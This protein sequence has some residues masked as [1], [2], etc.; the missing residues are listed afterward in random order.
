MK[1]YLTTIFLFVFSVAFFAQTQEVYKD[2]LN[3]NLI[4]TG[5]LF[6]KIKTP[7]ANLLLFT[8]KNNKTVNKPIEWLSL[9]HNIYQ[10]EYQTKLKHFLS[11][12]N[13]AKPKLK[14]SI[15]EIGILNYQFNKISEDAYKD[16]RA[17]FIDS[18]IIITNPNVIEKYQVF[19]VSPIMVKKNT[20]KTISFRFNQNTYFSNYESPVNY[21]MV[22]FGNNSGK[23]K[24]FLNDLISVKYNTFGKKNL[25][26]E[27]FLQN[28]EHFNSNFQIEVTKMVMPTPNETWANYTA[29]ISY[30]GGFAS[31]DVGVFLGYGNT[32]FTRPV[33]ISDG[34]DPGDTRDLSQ[35]YDLINQQNMVENLR[36][37]G[38]DLIIVNFNGGDD[39]IQKNAML[40]VKV[41]QTINNRMLSAGTLKS[42][43]QIAVVGPSMSGLVSRYALRYMEQNGMN[44]NVRNWIA[45]DSPMKGANI[46]L[47]LQHWL[48]FYAQV[49]DVA[50]AQQALQAL[51]GPAAKQMLK[52]YYTATSGITAG[53]HSLFTSFYNEIN[54]MGFPQQT[55]KVAVSNGSGFGNGQ[56]YAPGTQTINYRYRSTL[57]DL[58]GDVWAIP[59]NSYQKIFFG[60]YD[61]WGFWSYEEE[62][63]YVNNTN[64]LDSSPGGTRATFQELAN[65]D[66]GGYGT[67]EAYYPN[68]AFIPTISALDTQNTTN[69]Y[70]NVDSNLNNLTTNFDKLYYP[71]TNQEHVQIT[72]ESYLWFEHEIVNYPPIFTS[73]PLLQID[74]DSL[75]SYTLTASDQNEWNTFN[76]EIITL[77]SWLTYDSLTNTI[78]GTPLYND[79]GN[80]SISLRVTDGLDESIQTF[81]ITVNSKCSNA[82]ITEWNGN[83]WTNGLPNYSKYTI[84][85]GNYD[86]ALNGT[87][88]ACSL[89]IITGNT[90]RVTENF[91][92]YI[93][94]DVE[95]FGEI[96]I[97]NNASFIQTS[98]KGNISGNGIYKVE[99]TVSNLTDYYNMVYW[100]SPL[101]STSFTFNDLLPNAWRYYS[102]DNQNQTWNQQTT[103]DI[104]LP[105]RG[106]VV[107]APT[108]FTGGD[109]PIVFQKNNDTFNNGIISNPVV[110]NGTGA[111]GDDDWNLLGNPYPSAIDFHQFV[112]DNPSIQGSYYLWTN[113]A[114][115]SGNNQQESGYSTYSLSGATSACANGNFTATRYISSMQGF[116]IEANSQG[117]IVFKNGQR[118]EF[119]NNFAS[120]NLNDSYN[121]LWL[122]LTSSNGNY[123][124]ILLDFNDQATLSIDRLYDAKATEDG[125]G[126]NFYSLSETTKLNI[127]AIPNLTDEDCTI[128]LGFKTTT[129]DDITFKLNDFEGILQQ[130]N[131]YLI[132]ELLGTIHNLKLTNYSF[133][134]TNNEDNN[135]FK[136]RITN[137]TLSNNSEDINDL[138]VYQN[139]NEL[140]FKNSQQQLSQI[141]IYDINGK[142]L[143]NINQI[144]RNDYQVPLHVNMQFVIIKVTFTNSQEVTKKLFIH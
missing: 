104:L 53:N 113:C 108:G 21:L 23:Q 106:Y 41:I 111:F 25:S 63:I 62:N 13:S 98:D 86:S 48:R 134:T 122:D 31:G 7:D 72:S 70:Y 10:A 69:P 143:F 68:H 132:D 140:I 138:I 36:N 93:E 66:T 83:I 14:N 50:G 9:Y 127:Q 139:G 141:T 88:E 135:R 118:T 74:E 49:A 58:D 4:K 73:S 92:V 51:Q 24:V 75:Y 115:L 101:N 19:A 112:Q 144:N 109:I 77:P 42:A 71:N 28:E 59:N 40:L 8:A 129:L 35:L 55:R 124:Q 90:L 142:K 100:S 102:F 56:P 43:N 39:Y 45:F 99:K 94:R 64:P 22:D 30:N 133:S 81:T 110:I 80:H 34:F 76:F 32:D 57:V 120:R 123:K 116:F 38:Y 11:V 82:P 16:G 6:E 12:E 84:I 29:D 95:N 52:Y 37:Q 3:T 89:K 121:R 60:V 85:N 18:K 5:V 79:I 125:S 78:S 136:L 61:E 1:L 46:P 2:K 97:A 130:K 119:N 103:T 96:I 17:K 87:I 44:H 128:P 15:Y 20:G 65:T 91:P 117:S 137:N 33:I 27:I 105:G 107:S 126:F 131:I 26:V 47:G 67:I 114:G 54:T